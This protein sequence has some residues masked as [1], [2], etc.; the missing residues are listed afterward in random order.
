M[1]FVDL[2]MPIY[3][4]MPVYPGDPEVEIEQVQTLEHDGWDMK[5]IH[6]NGHDGT[7]VNTP[8]HCKA[9]G[10]TLDDYSVEDFCGECVLYESDEDV[11]PGVGVVFS[12]LNI[13]QDMAN[14]IVERKP[15]FVGLSS[16]FEFDESVEQYL[17]Q[18][19]VICFERLANT[20]TLPKKFMFHGAPLPIQKGDGSPVRAYAIVES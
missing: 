1:K 3:S 9:G 19:D 4:G 2:T 20:E 7:H 17:L 18:H 14:V 13:T 10:N 11:Q 5:R 15:K 16:N 6:M 8:L 12:H